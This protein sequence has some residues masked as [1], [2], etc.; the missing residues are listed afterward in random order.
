MATKKTKD[1]KLILI[2]V[3][4][5][6]FTSGDGVT[7]YAHACKTKQ[8]AAEWIENEFNYEAECH[9]WDTITVTEKDIRDGKEF[10]SPIDDDPDHDYVWKVIFQ[11]C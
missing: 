10:K 9:E 1:P 5:L 7:A 11:D 8:E 3:A 6:D 4:Q 2:A